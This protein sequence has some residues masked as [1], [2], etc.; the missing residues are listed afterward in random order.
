MLAV[1]DTNVIISGLL[2]K[3]SCRRLLLSLKNKDF[4]LVINDII[5][6]EIE[7]VLAREKLSLLI[8][9]A[10]KEDILSFI[11][12]QA[13]FFKPKTKINICRDRKDNI[14]LE[15]AIEAKADIIVSGDKDLT[16]L[17]NFRKI[18]IITPKQFLEYLKK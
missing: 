6:K 11:K 12:S 9:K 5:F 2:T 10:E 13:L 15:T 4:T 14:I 7:F 17:K 1:I 8:N 16:I 18:P 3:G